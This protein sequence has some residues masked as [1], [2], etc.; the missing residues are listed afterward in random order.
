MVRKASLHFL[1]SY[2]INCENY[3]W[4][5][6]SPTPPGKEGA[7]NTFILLLSRETKRSFNHLKEKNHHDSPSDSDPTPRTVPN[8]GR[9]TQNPKGK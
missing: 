6:T 4:L 1:E 8:F 7:V 9:T 3:C 2:Y 5:F